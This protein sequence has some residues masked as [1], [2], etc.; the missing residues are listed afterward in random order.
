[1]MGQRT[2]STLSELLSAEIDA[3]VSE[4]DTMKSE[5]NIES[6]M[7]EIGFELNDDGGKGFTLSRA[8]ENDE[9]VVVSVDV[10]DVDSSVATDGLIDEE[11]AKEFGDDE[12][13]DEDSEINSV[14]FSATF[15]K[16]SQK[17]MIFHCLSDGEGVGIESVRFGAANDEDAYSGPT[18]EDLD[19]DLQHAMHAYLTERG[20]DEKLGHFVSAYAMMKENE[21]YIGWL[22]EMDRFVA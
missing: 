16:G 9:R 7:E 18:F 13:D 15:S 19:E 14:Y 1:M 3:A 10:E 5:A 20:V 6:I 17:D 22:E 4:Q 21:L 11:M 12:V 8:L 2:M